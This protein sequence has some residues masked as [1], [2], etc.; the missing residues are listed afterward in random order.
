MFAQLVN[1][2]TGH[3]MSERPVFYKLSPNTH[4]STHP[5]LL[6]SVCAI[7]MDLLDCTYFVF[8]QS[9]TFIQLFSVYI[10]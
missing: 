10:V 2:H 1:G 6:Y 5:N 9:A 3:V 7:C 8:G 4:P